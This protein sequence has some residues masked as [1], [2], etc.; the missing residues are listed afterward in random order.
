MTGKNLYWKKHKV[1]GCTTDTLYT[2]WDN[3]T[4][5]LLVYNG[6]YLQVF[7]A[8]FNMDIMDIIDN[9]EPIE[10]ILLPDD[11]LDTITIIEDP[12]EIDDSKEQKKD[13]DGILVWDHHKREY[14]IK[15]HYSNS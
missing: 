15:R 5:E 8:I 12:E 2:A 11:F 6:E 3:E 9:I 4:E 13:D 10:I 7:P 14:I 1:T